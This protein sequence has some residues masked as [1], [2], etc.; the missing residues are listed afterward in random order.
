MALRVL[1][2]ASDG[3]G[4]EARI[5]IQWSFLWLAMP[6]RTYVGS[7]TVWHELPSFRRPSISKEM[8]LCSHWNLW[9][10]LSR[11][12]EHPDRRAALNEDALTGGY[13]E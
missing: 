10:H 8:W 2:V 4:D 3:N 5:T 1:T 6:C 11:A 7:G 12:S 13:P 9:R